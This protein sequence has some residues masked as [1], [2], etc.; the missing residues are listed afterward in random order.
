MT[1]GDS[2]AT[3]AEGLRGNA[4]NVIANAFTK[5]AAASAVVSAR[6]AP[7]TGKSRCLERQPLAG[8]A[9]QRR[10]AGD[11][12]RAHKE[13]N[14]RPRH[15]SQQAPELLD[16]PCPGRREDASRTE[17]QEAFERRVVEHMVETGRQ[18]DCADV[19]AAVGQTHHPCTKAE[20]ND[21]DILDAVVRQET[22]EIV[23]H[24]RVQHP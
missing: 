14:A 18:P 4:T 23:L 7:P 9:V 10:Q 11:R 17:K 22:F 24:Q 20:Q 5:Q 16:L 13:T 3:A 12:H 21:A 15:P 6:R 19:V 2:V 1:I 8:E